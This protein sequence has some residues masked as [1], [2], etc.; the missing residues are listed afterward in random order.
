M[1]NTRQQE[2]ER[3]EKTL[4]EH[5]QWIQNSQAIHEDNQAAIAQLNLQLQSMF[6]NLKNQLDE[7]Q[8]R[9]IQNSVQEPRLARLGRLDFP[10]FNGED[11]DGW[12]YKCNHF[13]LVDKTPEQSKVQFAIVNLEGLALRWHQGFVASQDRP[14]EAI[15]WADYVR[16]ITAR[17]SDNLW[18][19]AME[20]IKNLQ[21]T[22]SLSDYCNA[23]DNLMTKVVLSK[24]YT[25]SLFVGGLKPEIRCLVKVFRPRTL[26]EAYAMAKQQDNVHTTLFGTKKVGSSLSSHS[27][28]T[29]SFT[30]RNST[31]SATLPTPPNKSLKTVRRLSTKEADEKRARGECFFCPEKYSATH[32]C[33]NRQLFVIEIL[34]DDNCEG[35][36]EQVEIVDVERQQ[37]ESVIR[38]H[39]SIHAIS[40]IPSY[41]T[42]R[43]IGYIG[44]RKLH[45]L[46]DSGSTH[47]FI[48]ER[49][50]IKL[51]GSTCAVPSMRVTVA[52]GHPICCGQICKKF[53]WMMQGSWFE[54]DMYLIP[55]E[56]YDMVLGIQWLSALGDIV[57]NFKNL[58]MEFQFNGIKQVLKGITN[59]GVSLCSV[60]KMDQML[61]HPDQL[62]ESQMFSLQLLTVEG[63]SVHSSQVSNVIVD[64]R[65][66]KL[67]KQFEDVFQEP[68]SLPPTRDCTIQFF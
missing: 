10:K 20:E 7:F 5:G 38:P 44:T 12:I 18:E 28:N 40:G 54:A 51:Q 63:Q 4:K 34:D 31:V 57:W 48:N 62:I 19:D 61:G 35:D 59:S 32:K 64:P 33:K 8:G 26:R 27:A 2:M 1:T 65:I 3:F 24:E 50:S 46:I 66:A 13:F 68:K 23:F 47:N 55:L 43:V 41:S 17:F 29:S 45:I 36:E 58:G 49:L 53:K 22:G 14:I 16:S 56:S 30:P 15:P 9:T 67:L 6:E 39:I 25:A 60:E 42:M 52:N 11:V 21:Q 37:L